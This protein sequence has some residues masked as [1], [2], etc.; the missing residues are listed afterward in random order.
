MVV[1]GVVVVDAD[2]L[3][4][5]AVEDVTVLT[6]AVGADVV[7]ASTNGPL[8]REQDASKMAATATASARRM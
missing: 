3:L 7:G 5:R 2:A 4:V 6:G 1:A 8:L